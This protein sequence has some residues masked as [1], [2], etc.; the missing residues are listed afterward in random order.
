MLRRPLSVLKY[1]MTLDGKIAT[2][3]GHSAWVS[4]P[5]SRWAV[6]GAWIWWGRGMGRAGGRVRGL[7]TGLRWDK[8]WV[9]SEAH[10]IA[11]PGLVGRVR[12]AGDWTGA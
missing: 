8:V 11:G 6:G 12:E 5:Q 9:E 3:M 7:A 2:N 4:S 10:R 1:A